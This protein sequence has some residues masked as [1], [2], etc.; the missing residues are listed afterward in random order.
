MKNITS[1]IYSI[2][3]V[4]SIILCLP[5]NILA[6]DFVVVIDAG[7]GG[8]DGGAVGT[9]A[10]EKDITLNVAKL[11]GSKIS[12]ECENIKV[13]YTRDTDKYLTL[14][15]RANIANRAKGDLFIS[16]HVNSVDL[17]SPGRT[18]VAGSSVFTLGLHKTKDNLDVAMRE[19][20][21]I[22][23]EDN[24]T[25]VYSGFDPNSA[26][27]Y[28][29]F[30]M[31]QNK[32]M[33]KSINLA[34]SIQNELTTNAGR[35]DKGVRQAGFWVLWATNMPSVLVELDFICNPT[36]EKFLS[37]TDGQEQLANSIFNAFVKHVSN[38]NSNM[39]RPD[40]KVSKENARSIEKS[41]K[42]NSIQ[43]QST[44]TTEFTQV[45]NND[46]TISSDEIIYK[47]QILTSDKILRDNSREFKGLHPI[48]HY[49]D[50]RIYKY[51]YESTTSLQDA[52]VIL[53]N[54]KDKFPQAFI[55]KFKNGKRIK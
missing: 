13:V 6:K 23:M 15:Q 2:I 52:E 42:N 36:Q 12:D 55:V 31:N 33:L 16:I 19:N 53:K 18:N 4:I 7:H 51:T 40:R 30:E 43:E 8:K 41:I 5:I 20:S 22:K 49:R 46:S 50:N 47:I 27:S 11:L 38:D 17:N 1:H 9:F 35:E 34:S 32:H 54:V 21:V 3:I 45:E 37:S 25:T 10:K 26:E 14:Q 29:I 39:Q 24:Y 48:W 44:L 28:I